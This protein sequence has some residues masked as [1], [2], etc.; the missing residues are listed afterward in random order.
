MKTTIKRNFSLLVFIA[1]S[2]IN[3][4]AQPK[5]KVEYFSTEQGLSHGTISEILK[6]AEGFMWF[7]TWDGINRFDGRNFTSY[8][9][10][11]GEMTQAGDYRIAQVK[12]DQA[13]CIWIRTRYEK[14]YR[15]DKKTNYFLPI[16]SVIAPGVKEKINIDSIIAVKNGFVWLLS[17]K[18]GIYCLRQDKVTK[19]N[20]LRFGTDQPKEFNLPSY[21]ITVFHEDL[22]RRVWIATTAGLSCL[23]QSS[24]GIYKKINLVPYELA[25][26]RVTHVVEDETNLYFS[27]DDGHV[28]SYNKKSLA[29]STK[30]ISESRINKL[31]RSQR[32]NILYAVTPNGK[33]ISLNLSNHRTSVAQY[34]NENLQSIYEDRRGVLWLEPRDSGVIRF[35]PA[36]S[37]FSFFSKNIKDPKKILGNRFKVFEDN[38][39]TVWVNMKSG[40][41]GYY[42]PA[43]SSME[44]TLDAVNMP[45]FRL[46]QAVYHIYYDSIGVLWLRIHGGVLARIIFQ[47]NNFK[48][49]LLVDREADL[50][51][52]EVRGILCD[53]KNRLWLASKSGKLYLRQDDQFV[54]DFFV[55]EPAGGLGNVYVIYQDS[56]DNI[57]FGTK[58]SGLFRAT[59]TD[60]KGTKYRLQHFRN[61]K[62]DNES[63][64]SDYIYSII[65][66]KKG[67]I[68]IGTFA[69][70]M[71]LAEEQNKSVKFIHTGNAFKNYP[72]EGFDHI[73]H[74]ALD[75]SGNIWIA[76]TDGLLIFNSDDQHSPAYA[77]KIYRRVSDNTTGMGSSD[78]QFIYSDWKGRMWLATSGAGISLATGNPFEQLHFKNYTKKDGLPNDY[79]VSCSGDRQ[80]NLWIATENVLSRFNPEKNIFRNFDSYDGLPRTS[81]SEAA[82]CRELS[83]GNLVFGTS[84]GY[85]TFDPDHVSMKSVPANIVFTKMQINKEDVLPSGNNDITTSDINYTD[86]LV[87]KYNENIIDIDYAILDARAGNRQAFVYRLVGFDTIWHTDREFKGVSYTN[88][89]YGEYVLEVQ[90]LYSDLYSNKPYKRLPITILPPPW[91]TSWAYLSYAFVLLLILLAIRHY[92]LKMVRLKHK[93]IVEQK[94]AALKLNFF[95]G[96]SHELRTPL[97]LIVNPLEAIARKENL[98]SEGAAYMEVARKNANRMV[99]FI[100]QLLDLRKVQSEKATLKLSRVEIVS[101]VHKISDHFEEAVSS[102][103]ITLEILP[104][105]QEIFAF[106]D[107]EKF[108]VILYNLL[109]NAIKF[110][111]ERKMIKILIQSVPDENAFSIA[112][113]D[114]GPGVK[115]DKLERIFD[116]FQEGDHPPGYDF[117][118]VGIGLS[119]TKEFITLHGGMIMAAN[120]D[121]G[122]LTMTVKMK[123]G[124]EHYSNVPFSFAHSET[125]DNAEKESSV[126]LPGN[127]AGEN[128][129]LSP[130][131]ELPLLL[132]VEDNTDLRQFLSKQLSEFYRV[133]VASDGKEGWEKALNLLPDLIV[134]DVMMPVMDGIQL[135]DKLKNDINTSHI[136]VVLLSAKYS[137]ESQ[138]EGLNYGADYYITK[139]FNNDLLVASINNLLRQRQK[140]FELMVQRK[141][142]E[143]LDPTPILVT[144]KD[145]T[146]IKKV[147]LAVEDKMADPQFRIE[148]IA[149][150]MNM[151]QKTF[152]RKFKSL[153]GTTPAEFVRDIRLK[154]AKQFLDIPENNISDVAYLVGFSSPKYFSTCFKEKYGVSPSEY[155]SSVSSQQSAAV[156]RQ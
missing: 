127:K 76:A 145:E 66:D 142:P 60:S 14:V 113:H 150:I 130:G 87:L 134:S 58:G 106:V 120:N 8:K 17:R 51:D 62:R 78:I 70:G 154:K 146:F 68:W 43:R 42:N 56:R 13:G 67:R 118:S 19:E 44:Y 98:S 97:T 148:T 95:T 16:N 9:S 110:T 107:V 6:D 52:N 83:N 18:N 53:N 15:F 38:D 103:R 10:S 133:Q 30:K 117:K 55:N 104:D 138:V 128:E 48:Q 12:E 24:G 126:A 153:T 151:S 39:G 2:T 96:V 54:K 63:V 28:I 139:P 7:G 36:T 122:G 59:P 152:Y 91:K 37:S 47:E 20:V 40:G 23:V 35:D 144:S 31:L 119:L 94:L 21:N 4:I 61:D 46:P 72:K 86:K 1:F 64:T 99:R 136:P 49:Q 79:V 33:V 5:C 45:G 108:D 26:K 132:L 156:S 149:E 109:N 3:T 131:I 69:T 114:R 77:Y 102:K 101:F 112:V 135:L 125:K 129:R 105:Q 85:L 65:E 116:L 75:R 82:A 115:P 27:T 80:G 143:S 89:P 147:I 111:P 93:V 137:I 34:R 100:D 155:Q 81:F 124:F 84:Q 22:N 92:A 121:D 74:M 25:E 88:L 123:T 73:R 29:F 57:W 141:R 140:L 50:M 90:S 32:D 41:F 71:M 11:Q